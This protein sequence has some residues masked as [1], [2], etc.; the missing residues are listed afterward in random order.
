MNTAPDV[1]PFLIKFWSAVAIFFGGVLIYFEYRHDHGV[2]RDN[3]FW[4]F[5]GA[6][7]VVLG[8]INLLQ[9]RPQPRDDAD[10]PHEPPKLSD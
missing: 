8:A 1:K 4:L 6:M 3:V 7:V 2:T 9:K 5:V 10:D